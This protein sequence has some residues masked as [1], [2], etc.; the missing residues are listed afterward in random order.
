MG[1][2]MAEKILA[3]AS[4]AS[5]VKAGDIVFAK[6]DRAMMDDILGPRVSI[7]E[8]I[9]ELDLPLKDTEK[10]V[11]ISDHY[12]PPAS[13]HQA[14]IVKFTRDWSAAH[15]VKQ[16]YEFVGPCHQIMAETGNVRPWWV[17]V[18]TDSHT[19]MGGAL[20]AFATGIG[21]TEMLGVLVTGEIWFKVPETIK[22][23]WC[24]VLKPGVMAKDMSLA[25]IGRIGHAGA[26]YMSV[27]YVG[28]GITAL[29]LEQ[30]MAITNMAVEMGAKVGLMVPDSKVTEFLKS[31]DIPADFEP[32]ASDADAV[33]CRSETFSASELVPLVAC[34]HAVDNVRPVAEVGDIP[35]HQAYLGSCTGGRHSDLVAAASILRDRKIA[36]NVRMLV[37]PAS[38]N[39]WLRASEDGTLAILAEAGATILA[40]TCGVCVGL[41]SGL[42]AANENCISSSN[43]NFIGRMGSKEAGIYLG[44]PMTVAASAIKG[45]LASPLEFI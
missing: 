44:S 6:V 1:M 20:G 25:T 3:R 40:P 12:T 23:E 35:I 17:V 5:R 28:D 41:H 16:Y 18:G 36:K 34:P 7:D 30:R 13:V 38:Q 15:G 33:F 31:R 37:S 14:E 4:G 19:C 22:V 24:G 11:V 29:E 9:R 10:V 26:T 45:T 43:R 32:L 39:T 2:T 8:G 27:E 42:L 21:S